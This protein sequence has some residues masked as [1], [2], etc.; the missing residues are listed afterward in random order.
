MTAA[1]EHPRAPIPRVVT[2]AL[3][4]LAAVGLGMGGVLVLLPVRTD[5]YFAWTI[6]APIAAAT[7]GVSYLALG[8]FALALLRAH[9]LA[10]R[11]ALPMFALGSSLMLLATGLHR[12]AFN[13][14]LPMAW[15][16]LGLYLASPPVF[17]ALSAL[18]GLPEADPAIAPDPPRR[19][20]RVLASLHGAVAALLFAWPTLLLPAWPWPLLPLGARTAAAFLAGYALWV[21]LVA[22]A[23]RAALPCLPLAWLWLFPLVGLAAPGLQPGVFR[24]AS[25]GGLVYLCTLAA[26]ALLGLWAARA[27]RSRHAP[28]RTDA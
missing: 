16:W 4:F 23:P 7:L 6:K 10:I 20:L 28:D 11:T 15:V 22:R 26:T 18:V 24:A 12:A 21:W 19:L 8:A 14:G 5:R 3:L 13:W 25:P 9:L 2:S 27:L 17:L 1:P